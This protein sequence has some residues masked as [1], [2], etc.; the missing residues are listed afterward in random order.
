MW[1]M[2]PEH[3]NSRE[4]CLLAL[5]SEILNFVIYIDK[6]VEECSKVHYKLNTLWELLGKESC[7][8][9]TIKYYSTK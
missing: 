1:P 5:R 4:A 9:S 3:L 6:I 7:V 8:V 2:G